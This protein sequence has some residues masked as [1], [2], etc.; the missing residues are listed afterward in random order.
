MND[1]INNGGRVDE[2]KLL[3]QDSWSIKRNL[4][5][6]HL[7]KRFVTNAGA[8]KAKKIVQFNMNIGIKK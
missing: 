7:S 6:F 2:I 3:T 1:K 8:L 4:T 5:K